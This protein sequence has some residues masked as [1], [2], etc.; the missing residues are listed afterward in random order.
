[1]HGIF[2]SSDSPSRYRTLPLSFIHHELAFDSIA[3]ARDFLMSNSAAF[4][5]NPNSPDIEK[6]LDCKPAFPNL[7]HAYEEKHRKVNIKGA[8]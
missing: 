3:L 8:I 6:I 5:T 4:F 2:F 1:L 7:A